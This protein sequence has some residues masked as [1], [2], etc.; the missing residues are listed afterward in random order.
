MAGCLPVISHHNDK[1]RDA[2]P[3]AALA[4]YAVFVFGGSMF[5]TVLHLCR[6][7]VSAA[8]LP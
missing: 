4:G 3:L 2:A 5:F 7:D 6:Q 8:A 1:G